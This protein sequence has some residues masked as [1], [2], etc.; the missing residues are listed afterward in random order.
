M[1]CVLL[2]AVVLL[3]VSGTAAAQEPEPSGSQ[4]LRLIGNSP[5]VDPAPNVSVR[6]SDLAFWGDR[7]YAGNYGGF[8]II[9][10][11]RPSS[12]RELA[13]V[14]CF[15]PQNDVSV[16]NNE[17]LFL[18]VDSPQT[19]PRC[20]GSRT[21]TFAETPDAFEGIRI[22]DVS[23]PRDPV[24]LT[25]VAT[26]CGSHTHTLVPDLENDRLLVYVSSYALG[27]SSIGPD[28]PAPTP[29]DPV[30]HD[31]ISIVEVPLED[32]RDSAVINEPG[33]MFEGGEVCTPTLTNP[34]FP[35]LDDDFIC[36]PTDDESEPFASRGCHDIQVLLEARLAAC[37]ALAEGQLWDISDLEEPRLLKRVDNP[38][39]EF[40]HNAV[41]TWDGRYVVFT[42]EAGG[43]G[44]PW[45]AAGVPATIGANWVF[46]VEGD[47]AEAVS[48]YKTPRTSLGNCT[49]HN[50][51][52]IPVRDRYLHVRADNTA[53]TSV[54]D[55]TDLAAPEEIA[56]FDLPDASPW[57]SY[58]YNGFVYVNGRRRGLDVLVLRDR[59]RREAR[60]FSHL[61]PQ[62]QMEV[63]FA[64]DPDH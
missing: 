20:G 62:T 7:A 37:S 15:G 19:T 31:K 52:L 9:D 59:A 10:I 11:S 3:A 53:G 55:F 46:P 21:T 41:F 33:E 57:S 47:V 44:D 4:A 28:C 35:G 49:S 60:D 58:F 23:E 1:L 14:R 43:G 12:P 50:G 40:W 26:D 39:V 34:F 56:F 45:C 5:L 16:W 6:G 25:A 22:F 32:P 30:S 2:G 42:D 18:S 51:N 27:A 61:N 24:F 13:D 64:P 54:F 38:N 8:R 36:N 17:L 29:E 48:S 63:L